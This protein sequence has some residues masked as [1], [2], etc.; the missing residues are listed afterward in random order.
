MAASLRVMGHGDLP[1]ISCQICVDLDKYEL[2]RCLYVS[3]DV[4]DASSPGYAIVLSI[5]VC[6]YS[7]DMCV[8]A[9]AGLVR[10]CMSWFLST[11][12]CFCIVRSCSRNDGVASGITLLSSDWICCVLSVSVADCRGVRII[13]VCG[14]S[15]WVLLVSA[16]AI[17]VSCIG[18]GFVVG[19]CMLCILVVDVCGYFSKN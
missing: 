12:I 11:S 9:V 4:L 1:E 6:Q 7:L 19:G 13:G 8:L 17:G 10:C 14:A 2:S 3:F 16:I 18:V 15:R 5:G